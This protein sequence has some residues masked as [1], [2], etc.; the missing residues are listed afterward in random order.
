VKW[1]AAALI[2]AATI[3]AVPLARA[4][5]PAPTPPH[6]VSTSPAPTASTTPS[7]PPNALQGFSQNRDKPLKITSASLEV[8][9]KEKIATFNGDVHLVQGDTT[10]RS[11]TLVVFYD[12]EA[13]A[14]S[15]ASKPDASKPD[16]QKPANPPAAAG[17][18]NTDAAPMS[19]QIKRVEAKGG[20]L[21]TQKDQTAT[22][23]SGIFDMQAN[24]VTLLGNV[25][26]S[27][28]QNVVRGD[29]LTVDLNSG[30]SRVECGKSQGQC[31]VQALIQPSSMKGDKDKPGTEAPAS[32]G[33]V[34]EAP[35]SRSPTSGLY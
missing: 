35:R 23:E 15:D 21:V 12:D 32:T 4:A 16:A 27:Q 18:G 7:G 3:V 11:K 2:I 19:Q 26:I 24:T 13:D 34:R 1:C 28:G 22:G 31:R 29:R 20:V 25:V 6:P 30:V 9:D 5:S 10:L 17:A 8:R 33:T 14:K